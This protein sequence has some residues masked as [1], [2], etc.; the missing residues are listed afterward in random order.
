MHTNTHKYMYTLWDGQSCR[1][2]DNVR[3]Q[4]VGLALSSHL[5]G[6]RDLGQVIMLGGKVIYLMTHHFGP[7][8]GKNH[9]IMDIFKYLCDSHC[10]FYMSSDS[11]ESACV[12]C[13]TLYSINQN[14][15]EL[16]IVQFPVLC[17]YTVLTAY[18]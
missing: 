4:F 18:S 6:P 3:G 11:S 7:F 9:Q 13:F 5:I 8:L 14:P 15:S 1:A 17:Y 16:P 2:R 12:V 10:S